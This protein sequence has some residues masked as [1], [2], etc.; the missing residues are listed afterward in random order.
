[1]DDLQLTAASG[2]PVTYTAD[3][4]KALTRA[5]VR[6]PSAHVKRTVP[7]TRSAY[8]H[9][10][11]GANLLRMRLRSTNLTSKSLE[12]LPRSCAVLL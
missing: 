11:A 7:F 10:H 1:M 2:Q 6:F 12:R 3:Q 8:P 5:D 9:Q 4:I